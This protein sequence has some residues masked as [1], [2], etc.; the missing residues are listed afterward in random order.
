MKD[1]VIVLNETEKFYVLDELTY[2]NKKFILCLQPDEE[3]E[4]SESETRVFE[5]AVKDESLITKPIEDF[6]I[7]SVVNNMFI[8][9]QL[10]ENKN[11]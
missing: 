3:G 4:I 6:E 9:R 2:K 7:A 5:V 11:S 8:A 1:N 10:E